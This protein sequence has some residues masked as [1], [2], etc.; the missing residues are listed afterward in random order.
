MSTRSPSAALVGAQRP[1]VASVPRCASSSGREAVEVAAVAGLDLD[2]WE[3]WTLEQALGE[4]SDGKW[5]GFE[6]ATLVPRQN[7]KGSIIEARELAGAF[8]FG[9]RRIVHTAHE[10]K[11]AQEGFTR[12]LSLIDNV[13]D[14][15]KKVK[16]VRTSHGEEGIELFGGQEI[17]FIARS[18]SSGRGFGGDVVILDEA[19]ALTAPMMGTLVPIMA[20]KPN[21]QI[22]YASS[23]GDELAIQ[24]RRIRARGHEGDPRMCFLEWS[25]EEHA[26]L[27]DRR[28]WAQAN[29]GLG[30]RLTE[31]FI[32]NERKI[33][34]DDEFA[35]ERLGIWTLGQRERVIPDEAWQRAQDEEASPSGSMR[36]GLDVLPDRS[37]GAIA[38]CGNL[39]V[40]LIDHHSGVNWMVTRGVRLARKWDATIVID[41]GGPARTIGDELEKRGVTVERLSGPE[42]GDACA[43]FFD[44]ITKRRRG[45]KVLPHDSLSAAVAGVVKKKVGDR[46]VWD[47]TK[48]SADVTPLMAATLAATEGDDGEGDFVFVG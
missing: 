31:E 15:S 5:A 41:G 36:F 6:V 34:E 26:N 45:L 21:P 17:R 48:S 29:P 2:P 28:A 9:E 32:A 40:E 27:D 22:W 14:F 13:D 33:L 11:T 16:K 7:G 4:R 38:A 3:A 8:V 25:A 39:T 24:L 44:H 20:T 12:L 23:A 42:V 10:F 18:K 19:F 43:Y 30:Y 37:A 46:F 47:R 1:R 35:R